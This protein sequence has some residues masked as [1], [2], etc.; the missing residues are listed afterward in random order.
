[1]IALPL[2]AGGVVPNVKKPAKFLQP[3]QLVVSDKPMQV[4]T[5][6][7]SCVAVCLFDHKLRIGGVNH[8]MLPLFSGNGASS[9]RFGDVA[10]RQLLEG[11]RALGARIPLLEARVF[12]GACMFPGMQSAD[13]LGHKNAELALDFLYRAGIEVVQADTGGDRGRKVIYQTD[14]GTACLISI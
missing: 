5:I 13:H 7:G 8:F 12:G 3:G 4:T 6:L 10:M 1:V 14:E 2:E 9:A 11:M